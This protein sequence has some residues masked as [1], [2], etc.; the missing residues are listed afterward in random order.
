MT[1]DTA[2][3][4][5]IQ[6]VDRAL[7]VLEA[8][9]EQP[10]IGLAALARR[11]GATKTLAFRMAATLEARGYLLKDFE[12]K[13]YWL[14]HRPLWLGEQVAAH[15]PLLRAAGPVLDQLAAQTRENASLLVRE[16]TECVVVAVRQSPQPIRLYAEPGRRGPLHV[17]GGPKLLLAF[18]PAEVQRAVLAAEL[19]AFTPETVTDPARLATVLA[20]I[21][22]RGHNV[23]HGDL[24]AGAF[25]VATP[26]RDHAGRVAASISVAGP[27]SRLTPDLERQYVRMCRAAAEELSQRLGWQARAA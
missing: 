13:T 7:A 25:S 18:A 19:P 20:G 10:G 12:A 2:P 5:T 4:Y 14:G 9:A 27:Q 6:A 26:V 3:D 8:V 11:V 21:R 22:R 23:S 1:E 17:G 15:S 16:G 24:D